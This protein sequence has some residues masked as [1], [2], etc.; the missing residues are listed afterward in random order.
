MADVFLHVGLPKTGTTTIQA[1]LDASAGA[2]AR[3][4]VLVAGGSHHAQRRAVYDLLGQRVAGEERGVV[5]GSLRRLLDEV[6]AH[7]GR[8]VV[9]SEEELSLARPRHVR[10]LV[11]GFAGHRVFV[12]VGVRDMARTLV[13]AW[14]QS[15]VNCSTTRWTDFVASARG[16]EGAPPSEGAAFWLRHDV[17]R[18]VDTWSTAVPPE[19]IRLVTVPPPG[20]GSSV[21]L[22][23]FGAAAELPAR[24]WHA[25][26]SPRNVS[27]GAAE[28]EVVRR[29]NVAVGG[30]LTTSQHRFVIEA[31]IR[32]RLAGAGGRP[33]VLPERHFSWA[34]EHGERLVAELR[35][36]DL[37]V[38][39]SLADLVPT[40]PCAGAPDPDDVRPHELLAATEAALASLALDH[41][42]LFRR[43]RR[44]FFD[45]EG[46][47]PGAAEVLASQARAGSFRARKWALSHADEDPALARLLRLYLA[48]TSPASRRSDG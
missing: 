20:A 30:R 36:R 44:A 3:T 12:V 45:R 15:V 18:V 48:R 27:L 41:G 17:L 47:W 8:S 14:Q 46:R 38:Y 43:F 23:R 7:E 24:A 39:G 33:L 32:A 19:R 6:A 21:L 31:G 25:P 37:R 34:Q 28:L 10:M 40:R 5:A 2:L 26:A 9:L 35:R 42:R 4:G 16:E 13:S 29:L 11:R 1:A 22:D